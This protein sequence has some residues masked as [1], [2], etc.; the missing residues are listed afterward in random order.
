MTAVTRQYD[1]AIAG[2]G[3]AGASLACALG[4]HGL[5]VALID[6]TPPAARKQTGFDERSITLTAGSAR[7]Y[8]G[9]GVWSRLV[10]QATAIRTIHISEAGAFGSTRLDARDENVDALGYVIN[11]REFGNLLQDSAAALPQVSFLCPA[12]VESVAATAEHIEVSLQGEQ[13][14]ARISA[15]LLVGA[16]GADSTVRRA[17]GISA[18]TR[19]YE[20]MAIVTHVDVERI[21]PNA[22]YER[23]TRDGVIALL[24]LQGQRCG[25]IWMLRTKTA[26]EMLALSDDAALAHLQRD[27]GARLGT[28]SHPGKRYSYPLKLVQSQQQIRRR[29]VLIGNAAHALHP[30]GGQGFNLGLRDIAALAELLVDAHRIGDDIG[31]SE[32]LENY[33][34]WRARDQRRTVAFTDTLARVFDSEW[35]APLRPLGFIAAN[36]L[37]PVRHRIAR[38]AMGLTGRLPRLARG[39]PL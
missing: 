35:F 25:V 26:R 5:S 13:V 8:D 4:A 12:R 34:Q 10:A 39:V 37:P 15:R 3:F 20:Q 36:A 29:A 24:P 28:L 9:L 1:V 11:A 19:D 32:V 14:P 21:A 23:F 22:A 38:A 17:L 18:T 33:V 30:I 27:F 6:P 2:A 31:S 7:I 16:D